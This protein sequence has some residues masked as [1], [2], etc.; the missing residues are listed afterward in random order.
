VKDL[1]SLKEALI[2]AFR[3]QLEIAKE[4]IL[5]A[6]DEKIAASK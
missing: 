3:E 4:D 5:R 6:V 1:E 2:V